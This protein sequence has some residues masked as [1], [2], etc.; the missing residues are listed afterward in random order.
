MAF[1][2]TELHSSGAR[3]IAHRLKSISAGNVLDVATGNGDFILTLMKTLKDYD[4]FIGIDTS[5]KELE[6]ARKN[7]K[8][9]PAKF[10]RMNAEK[11]DFEGDY[12]DTVCIANSLH[13]L[14]N[15]NLVLSEM[16]RVLKSD[17]YFI[18]Q[19]MF[20]DGEQT[21][22]QKTDIAS[23]GLGAEI[24]SLFGIPHRRT[25]T[26]RR[27]ADVVKKLELEKVEVFESSRYIKCLFCDQWK[28]CQDPKDRDMV[29]Y[30]LTEIDRDLERLENHQAQRRFKEK[31]ERIRE[32]I[33]KFGSTP[34]SILF[35]IGKK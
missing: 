7:L 9:R 15:P 18:V 17:G 14:V 30:A 4:S 21:K 25:F 2:S 20:C 35:F 32:K 10:I 8:N 29:N 28:K 3:S 12:F 31:A 34:A 24:D 33:A 26:K 1:S 23:H 27:I 13:H 22:A 16:K 19:E 5:D 11:I 6:A